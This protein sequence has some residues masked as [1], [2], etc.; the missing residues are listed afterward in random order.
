VYNHINANHEKGYPAINTTAMKR[1]ILSLG[2]D[3]DAPWPEMDPGY[4]GTPIAGLPVYDALACAECTTFY[5]ALKTMHLHYNKAHPDIQMPRDLPTV[6]VQQI[7]KHRTHGTYFQVK[8]PFA[9]ANRAGPS[10]TFVERVLEEAA[11]TVQVTTYAQD[12]RQL[13]PFLLSTGWHTHVE[14][15][16]KAKVVELV[17]GPKAGDP[18]RGLQQLLFEYLRW[19]ARQRLTEN[20]L[21]RINTPIVEK[22]YAL[23]QQTA[24]IRQY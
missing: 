16:D 14:P 11:E 4:N 24:Q 17:A 21:R 9:Q 2:M 19:A 7:T 23:P 6:K 20:T 12:P 10:Q 15:H 13:H 22:G 18:Y 5:P 3:W 1:A 8:V